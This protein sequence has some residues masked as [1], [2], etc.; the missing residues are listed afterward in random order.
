VETRLTR[1]LPRLDSEP[2]APDRHAERN[3]ERRQSDQRAAPEQV[4]ATAF[5]HCWIVVADHAKSNLG[6]NVPPFRNPS[7]RRG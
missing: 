5:V 4:E 2:R 7:H 1:A 6:A 3:E